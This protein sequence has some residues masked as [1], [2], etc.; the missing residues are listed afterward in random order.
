MGWGWRWDPQPYLVFVWLPRLISISEY[1]LQ[2]I[3]Y[4]YHSVH[5]KLN[6]SQ[7]IFLLSY[8]HFI[9]LRAAI[10]LFFRR[11]TSVEGM[12]GTH[13]HNVSQSGCWD[14]PFAHNNLSQTLEKKDITDVLFF[15]GWV[16]GLEGGWPS[17]LLGVWSMELKKEQIIIW[18]QTLKALRQGRAIKKQHPWGLS[19]GS[20]HQGDGPVTSEDK[21]QHWHHKSSGKYRSKPRW[22]TTSGSAP[23]VRACSGSGL[24]PWRTW[25]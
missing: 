19:W 15:L 21:E 9:V 20:C 10:K 14:R 4:Y 13:K 24:I 1:S 3:L 5:S 6:S 25:W 22:D 11:G 16:V 7:L 23:S 2:F 17:I 18:A 12:E 8:K